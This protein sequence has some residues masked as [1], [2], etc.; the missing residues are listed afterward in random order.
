MRL[1]NLAWRARK[2]F[3]ASVSWLNTTILAVQ[4]LLNS[5]W[6][7]VVEYRDTILQFEG[8]TR[9]RRV[10][11]NTLMRYPIFDSI[12]WIFMISHHFIL[13][14]FGMFPKNNLKQF[15]WIGLLKE[16]INCVKERGL[17]IFLTNFSIMQECKNIK[18]RVWL[19]SIRVVTK[20]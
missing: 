8:I 12:F 17:V 2:L 18:D 20:A 13:N 6:S 10:C 15:V 16:M 9:F 1:D 4:E 19:F 11:H 3:L 7:L 5:L 14:Q